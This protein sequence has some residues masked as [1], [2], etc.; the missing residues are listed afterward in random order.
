MVCEIIS[1]GTEVLTGD[2]IDTN[3]PYL[4]K[5]LI[6][7]GI[8]ISYRTTVGDEDAMVYD[9]LEIAKKRAELIITIGGL[10]PTYDDFT[11]V[12]VATSL[13]LV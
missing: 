9:A 5:E 8:D 3:A 7:L 2:I 4:A 1:V 12:S 6:S 11:K 13:L 10:G